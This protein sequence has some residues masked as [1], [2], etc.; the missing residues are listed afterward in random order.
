MLGVIFLYVKL[1]RDQ[2]ICKQIL[3]QSPLRPFLEFR[4]NNDCTGLKNGFLQYRMP[5]LIGLT[6]H[7]S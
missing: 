6:L 7:S 3:N 5:V 4:P 2:I 1:T